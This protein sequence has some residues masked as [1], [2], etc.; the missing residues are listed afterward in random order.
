[1]QSK[2]RDILLLILA[3]IFSVALIFAFIELPRWIDSLLQQSGSFPGFDQGA[4]EENAYRSELFI[5][6][7][8]LRWIG[9]GSLILVLLFIVLG[10]VTRKS[11]W[12]WA[13]A[14]VLFLPVFGQFALSMFFLSGLGILRAGWL[15]LM[16]TG[17][18]VLNLGLV[19]YVPYWVL[20]WFFGLFNWYAHDFIAWLFMSFG[21]FLFVWGVFT[22]LQNRFGKSKMSTNFL[23]RYSRHPQYLGWILWSYGFMLLS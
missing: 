13:G 3:I 21:A 8:Y 1:M 10:F 20:L 5:N 2:G 17:F 14:F 7:L 11:S 16:E 6:A 4:G 23:Y 12:A 22:W 18:P 9:Y 19:I 15:P